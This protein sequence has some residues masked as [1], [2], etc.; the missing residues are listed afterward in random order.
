MI[1]QMAQGFAQLAHPVTFLYLAG[2][3]LLG[4]VFGAIP[5][6]TATL[7]IALLLPFTFGMEVTDALVMVAGIY[8][9]GIYAGSITGITLNIPGAPSGAISTDD[10][11]AL[12][13]RGEGTQALGMSAMSSAIGGLIG[14]VVLI[15]LA[16]P[17]SQLAL[18]FQT[19]DKFSL[20][21]LAVV[22]VTIVSS[23]SLLKAAVAMAI[24]LMISTVG[25]DP[26]L[27]E[28]RFDF[29][30][31]HLVEGIGL[32]PAVIGL[33]AVCELIAQAAI[34]AGLARADAVARIERPRRR[35]FMPSRAHIR[36]VGLLTYLKSAVIGVLIG[37]LPGGGASM[38]SFIA[39]AEAKRGARHPEIYGKGSYQGLAASESANNAMCGGAVIPLLT[40]GIPGDAVTAII[41]GVL[42]IHGLVPGPA[43]LGENF[44]VIAPMFAALFVSA[45]FVFLSI[46]AF[47]P[48]YLRLSRINRGVLYAFIALIS[49]VGVY[50]SSF[51]AFQMWMA[52][53]IGTLGFFMRRFGY[54]VVPA[55]MG[56][57]LGPFIEEFLRRSLIVSGGDPTIFLKSPA[58]VILLAMTVVFVWLLRVR[59]AR[60][61]R[62]AAQT[63]P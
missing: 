44:P 35:D 2:G 11:H 13:K 24:G 28:G 9:A 26:M 46:F 31:Y 10:G 48:V 51:S 36:E 40:M 50:A 49:M 19:P 21:L 61:A 17:V 47:G 27:P 18:M 37:M 22:T 59:P 41:F 14:T 5:G 7:A 12:M 15:V 8:M 1:G 38:A 16:Q 57:I 23:G 25:M 52:L 32:L 56:V 42:L 29:G 34:P 63:T 60:Q 43:L 39:Y 58:S 20:V 4:L 53:A 3:F 30:S 54:P 62:R 6:L 45:I 55:L 33:F